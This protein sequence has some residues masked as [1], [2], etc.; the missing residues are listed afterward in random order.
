MIFKLMK[1]FAVFMLLLVVAA[2]AFPVETKTVGSWHAQNGHTYK[3]IQVSVIV[4]P[5]IEGRLWINGAQ[6]YQLLF[7]ERDKLLKLVQAAAKRIDIATANK[8]TITY[9][10]ELGGF[11]TDEGAR[12][13]VSFE[14]E[15]HE[16]S[17][18]V[19]RI[20]D[21]GQYDILQLNRKDCQELLDVL[22][23]ADS[24]ISDYRRQVALFN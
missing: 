18:V 13:T 8:T 2:S 6:S 5:T 1:R 22:G 11:F 21:D 23:K 14:T 17:R 19:L 7:S 20:M 10:L 15:G 9:G 12:F 16:S 3:D 24:L 4:S